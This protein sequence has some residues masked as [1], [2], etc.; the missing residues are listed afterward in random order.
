MVEHQIEA[1]AESLL[2]AIRAPRA[3]KAASGRY[4]RSAPIR[5]GIRY[6]ATSQARYGQDLIGVQFF[7]RGMKEGERLSQTLERAGFLARTPQKSQLTY[8]KPIDYAAG[9][10]ID[11]DAAMDVRRLIDQL[12]GAATPERAATASESTFRSFMLGSPLGEI[13]L[14]LA[15]R[16]AAWRPGDL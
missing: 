11:R 5:T 12:L 13:D 10:R 15:D 9:G 3:T 1:R 8:A 4:L 7:G 16:K 2:E 6:W 14:P